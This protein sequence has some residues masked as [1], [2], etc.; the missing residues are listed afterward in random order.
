M[1]ILLLNT[2]MYPNIFKREA[3]ELIESQSREINKQIMFNYE[4]YVENVLETANY[5]QQISGELDIK[6]EHET[7]QRAY[8]TNSDVRTDVLGI[9]LFSLDGTPLVG[10]EVSLS[11]TGA[12]AQEKWFTQS[13]IED[14]IFYF[15][16]P[17]EK[18]IYQTNQVEVISIS[19]F[20]S[21]KDEDTLR[22][23]ILLIELTTDGL[24][25][26]ANLTNLGELGHLLM[27]DDKDNLIYNSRTDLPVTHEEVY[28]FA[29]THY[30]GMHHLVIENTAMVVQIHTLEGTRWRIVT[31]N[32]VNNIPT[33]ITTIWKLAFIMFLASLLITIIMSVGV[34]SRIT[35]PLK[36]LRNSMLKVEQ[37][38]FKTKLHISGQKELMIVAHAFNTMAEEIE[39]LMEKVVEE[40]REKRKTALQIFQNQITPHFLYNTLD[41][42]VWL[43]EHQRTQDVITT[44]TALA[45]FFR[46]SVSKG[47]TI[48][49]VQDEIAH[50]TSYLI[51]QKIRYN[52]RFTYT[53]EIEKELYP[54]A[55]MKLLLQPLVENAIEHGLH[56]EPEEITIRC[57]KKESS[58]V[59]EVINTGYGI[60]Q[61]QIDTIHET[62]K[63]PKK[64]ESVGMK[65][66]YRR[67]KLYYGE[68]ADLQVSSELDSYTKVTLTIPA[69]LLE[70][71]EAKGDSMDIDT[72][73]TAGGTQPSEEQL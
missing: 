27:I 44:V 49:S 50:I 43:A 59:F 67:V 9:T 39:S 4:Q 5:L 52:Q 23:G 18:S 14:S 45:R 6:K 37:G 57:S 35:R 48:I 68:S 55:T 61:E 46:I 22:Q 70:S 24:T 3:T 54:Y 28:P 41:S 25:R 60:T 47:R 10:R 53:I 16:A 19:K 31:A 72:H 62:M 30:F 32:N 20:I 21:Y 33:A 8:Q 71:T 17:H 56:D 38:H 64:Q 11:Y 63:N 69:V 73:S 51:I 42:I 66:V 26:L 65:N 15:S 13:I 2:L 7:L 34:A 1:V 58:L 36:E 12:I 29:V 40:Q